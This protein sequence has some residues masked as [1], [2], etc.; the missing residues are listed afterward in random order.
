MIAV[1]MSR[2]IVYLCFIGG[3]LFSGERTIEAR[4]IGKAEDWKKPFYEISH[5][6]VPDLKQNLPACLS[7]PFSIAMIRS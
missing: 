6:L 4:K 1:R 5:D 3:L 7:I 2:G